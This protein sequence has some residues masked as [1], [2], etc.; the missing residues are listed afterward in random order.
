MNSVSLT[1]VNKK[2]FLKKCR[3]ITACKPT[4][5]NRNLI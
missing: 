3:E 1:A 2:I 4:A 5:L